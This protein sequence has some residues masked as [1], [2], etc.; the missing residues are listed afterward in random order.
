M[1]SDSEKYPYEV[2]LV[3]LLENDLTDKEI[4][5]LNQWMNTDPHSIEKYSSFLRDYAIV[6]TLVT[7][8]LER[9]QN[10]LDDTEFDNAMWNAMLEFERNAPEIEVPR[11]Q[12]EKQPPIACAAVN[13]PCQPVRGRFHKFQL[14]TL[15]TSAAA[16]LLV[17]FYLYMTG[18][19]S[20]EEVATVTDTMNVKWADPMFSLKQGDRLLTNQSSLSLS[21]GIIEIQTDRGVTLTV[22]GP[23]EFEMMKEADL[24]LHSGR[25]FARVS[26]KGIGFTICTAN[27]RIIDLGTEFGIKAG[28]DETELHV[29]QGK[30]LL[31]SGTPDSSKQQCEVCRG[32]A[33]AVDVQ[34]SVQDIEVDGQEFIREIDSEKHFAWKGQGLN[35]ADM[36]GGGNGTGTGRLD[37]GINYEGKIRP[38]T[39]K[40]SQ[41]GPDAYV[42]VV[43]S[44]FVDGVF[45]PDG[46]TQVDSAGTIFERFEP[47]NHIY[48]L[49]VLNGAWHQIGLTVQVPRHRLRLNGQ[50]YGTSDHPAIYMSA[51][52]GVTFDLQAIRNYTSLEITGFTSLCGVSQSYRD[53]WH[54]MKQYAYFMETPRAT[55]YV[56]VDGQVR[57]VGTDMT[58]N[59][60]AAEI[61][62][63]ITSQD[64]FLTLAT[65]QGGDGSNNGDWT[66]FAVP[67][68]TV[69]DAPSK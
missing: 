24:Y 68:L 8:Q 26:P 21:R 53:Y 47:T 7:G 42:P 1:S 22:E 54:I 27:A 64:R 69:Q 55:F 10:D 43:S 46:S 2:L 56:L 38:L 6:Q 50:V 52:Q 67:T 20:S 37:A 57:F 3:R 31:I 61:S 36:V 18:P 29:M 49:G 65:T 16:V 4:E 32:Q 9:A 48:W 45:I 11:P 60:L 13:R 23:A 12:R 40:T 25:V 62:V 35:L 34:G 5:L 66:L 63:P 44:A 14:Y 59:D 41:R 39:T 51:N 19:Q 15:L 28:A 58:P 17:A 30:T 33:K